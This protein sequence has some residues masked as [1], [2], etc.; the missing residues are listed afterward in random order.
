MDFTDYQNASRRT[1]PEESYFEKMLEADDIA[2]NLQLLNWSMGLTGEAAEVMERI[3]KHV[4]HGHDATMEEYYA[5][6]NELGD[7]LWYIQALATALH[8]D[9]QVIAAENVTKLSKRYGEQFSVE[10]SKNRE[11]YDGR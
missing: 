7:A 2:F 5:I 6:R 11:E 3:K 10:A 9:L 1:M 8:M 4:F